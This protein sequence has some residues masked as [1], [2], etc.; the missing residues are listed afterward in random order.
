MAQAF[1]VR[2]DNLDQA[3]EVAIWAEGSGVKDGSSKWLH[4]ETTQDQVH[5]LSSNGTPS[6]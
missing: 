1:A 6:I 2:Q 5:L 4:L 3:T